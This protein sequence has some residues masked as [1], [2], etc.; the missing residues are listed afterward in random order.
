MVIDAVSDKV[1]NVLA[2]G[3]RIDYLTL[4]PDGEPT[5]DANLGV[6]IEGLRSLG[7][8]IAVISNASLIDHED[9]RAELAGADWVSLKV[10]ATRPDIWRRVDRPHGSL[11]LADILAGIRAFTSDYCGELVTETM[12]CG[13]FNDGPDHLGEVAAFL[14]EVHPSVAYITVPIRPPAE[15][16]VQLPSE[17]AVNEAYQL[18][19]DSVDQVEVLAGYEGNEFARS[20]DARHDLLSITAVHPMRDDAVS[21]LLDRSNA[22]WAVVQGLLE[23]GLLVESAYRGHKFY[24]RR[25]KR[26]TVHTILR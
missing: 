8:K 15:D 1:R 12:L 5:L 9:V 21:Q 14:A 23:A 13:G 10:D 24:V 22:G 3:D 18:F 26:S 6:V 11:R 7:I 25:L 16:W 4:V 20:G 2:A 17:A 19:S